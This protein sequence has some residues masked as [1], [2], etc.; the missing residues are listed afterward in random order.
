MDPERRLCLQKHLGIAV[1]NEKTNSSEI[2][3]QNIV[4]I[5]KAYLC[6]KSSTGDLTNLRNMVK[7][8]K[9]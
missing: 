5:F 8:T 1:S 2:R 7:R 6:S 3:I 9:L 4:Y